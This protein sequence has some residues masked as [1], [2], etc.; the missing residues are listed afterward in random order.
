ML[1]KDFYTNVI[2]SEAASVNFLQDHLLLG[3]AE[4]QDPCHKCGL[5]MAQKRRK[6]RSG[7]WVQACATYGRTHT[8]SLRTTH[9]YM[10]VDSITLVERTLKSHLGKY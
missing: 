7:E 2:S 3:G 9:A 10:Y 8:T 4:D 1:L 5:Q 6:S